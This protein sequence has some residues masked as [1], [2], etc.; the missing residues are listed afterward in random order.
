MSVSFVGRRDRS[1]TLAPIV[2]LIVL[3]ACADPTTSVPVAART[4]GVAAVVASATPTAVA[5][6][7]ITGYGVNDA[8]TIV[9]PSSGRTS[10]AYLWDTST[11]LEL[12]GS[13][14]FAWSIAGDGHTVGGKNAAGAPVVWTA[15]ALA[16][17]WT[18]RVIPDVGF[19]GAVRAIASDAFGAPVAMT[20][21]VWTNGSIKT[22]AR[23]TPC[24]VEPGCTNGWLLST[25]PLTPP[26][27][28]AWGQ[29]INPSGMIV[30]M[31]GSGCCRAAFWD[32]NNVQSILQPLVTGAAAAAWG[33]N[34]AG[35]IIVGQSNGV[36]VAWVRASTSVDF[37]TVAP[38]RLEGT[39]TCKGSA[40]SI[41][42]AVNPDFV[43]SGTIVGAACGVPVAWKV[44]VSVSPASI[45]KFVLP[46]TG[47][48][49]S[50]E[51]LSINRSTSP[52]YRIAGDVNGAG[53]YWTNF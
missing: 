7:N 13:G 8:G 11:G 46:S 23:W 15:T 10:S 21:N 29:D 2:V 5:I 9:G 45:V 30:G 42:Y 49:T 50:G 25:V 52:R 32:A 1:R 18:E 33:L 47:R 41:A 24:T 17:P 53:A 44:D 14:G 37:A 4:P 3:G 38:V 39:N 34:D 20:G 43:T 6:G 26:I 35:T 22:P 31:E 51:A 12:L 48:S 40:A 19:G 16:G 28:E 36:A 27:T